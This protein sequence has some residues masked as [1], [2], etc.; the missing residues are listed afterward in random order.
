[1][2]PNKYIIRVIKVIIGV[3]IEPFN[4]V[5][6]SRDYFKRLSIPHWSR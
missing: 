3:F 5:G 6:S 1:M 4:V 2:M